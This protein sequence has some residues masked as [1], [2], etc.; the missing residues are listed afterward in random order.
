MNTAKMS[1]Q[2]KQC[3]GEFKGNKYNALNLGNTILTTSTG[4]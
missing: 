4:C 3:V 1:E 2:A